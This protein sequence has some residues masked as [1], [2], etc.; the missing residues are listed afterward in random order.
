MEV[1]SKL[2][3][4]E[5]LDATEPGHKQ[6]RPDLLNYSGS[7]SQLTKNVATSDY[8]IMFTTV[9]LPSMPNIPNKDIEWMNRQLERRVYMKVKI[10]EFGLPEIVRQRLVE[11]AGSRYSA[12][13]D[14]LSLSCDE[15]QNKL[16]NKY[17]LKRVFSDLIA[18]AWKACDDYLPLA[19]PLPALPPSQPILR[20]NK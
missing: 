20:T 4:E 10:Q 14:V 17:F 19:P 1:V 3:I 2:T 7:K 12:E 9:H 8:P 11:L 18:E 5:F 15:S 6:Q 13:T 16:K